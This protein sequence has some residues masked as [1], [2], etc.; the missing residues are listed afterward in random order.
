MRNNTNIYPPIELR[1]RNKNYKNDKESNFAGA[2]KTGNDL[3]YPKIKN[4]QAVYKFAQV[5]IR[6]IITFSHQ[7]RLRSRI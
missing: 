1:T 5:G 4:P 7:K 6:R 2:S 3:L